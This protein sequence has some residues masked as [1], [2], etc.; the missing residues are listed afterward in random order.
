MELVEK[1]A[2]ILIVAILLISGYF[3]FCG[4]EESKDAKAPVINTITGNTTGIAGETVT[5]SVNFSDNVGVTNAMIYWKSESDSDWGFK[6]ILNGSVNIPLPSDSSENWYYYVTIDDTAGNGPVGDPSI[7]GSVHYTITVTKTGDDDDD[8]T[9]SRRYV[10]IEESTATTCQ[11]CPAVSDIIYELYE[12]KDYPFYYVSMVQDNEN[13]DERLQEHYNLYGNPTTYI[14]GGY[15]VIVGKKE[16]SVYEDKIQIAASR[17]APD[18]SVG[19]TAENNTN[20]SEIIVTVIVKNNENIAY[21]GTLKVYLTEI[22]STKWQNYDG[23][24]YH[25]SFLKF[26]MDKTITVSANSQESYTEH[27]DLAGLDLENLMIFAVVFSNEKHQGY[28]NPPNEKPFNA[29]YADAVNKTTV[30]EGGNLPP[31]V[32]IILP[33]K[34]R[35]HIF[36]KEIMATF[37][38]KTILLGRTTIKAQASDDSAISKVEFY[39][40]D[41]LVDEF[42]E[43]PYEWIWKTPSWFKLK[44]TLKVTA[45]DDEE[46]SSTATI[47]VVAFILL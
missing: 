18:L 16:K 33:K 23:I 14:D 37:S 43:P 32:G 45:Y 42:T 28:S 38:Q 41:Q 21:E 26:A 9:A 4:G 11:H 34:G 13:A 24:P 2:L 7:N 47:D 12:S 19:V 36:G 46:K 44:H 22:I 31:E 25:F 17:N 35:L 1:L 29:Y 30:V 5:I 6:S 27:I 15:K 40:D 20:D 3:L 10:F 8:D 39:L